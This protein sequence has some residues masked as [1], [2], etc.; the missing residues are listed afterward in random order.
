MSFA[1]WPGQKYSMCYFNAAIG[2]TITQKTA[3]TRTR[4]L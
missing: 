3:R 1:N 4:A 2:T